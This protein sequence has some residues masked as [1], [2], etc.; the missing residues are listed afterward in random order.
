MQKKATIV[1]GVD[2]GYGRC[3]WA[4]IAK[5][6]R[7]RYGCIETAKEKS[8]PERLAIIA[9]ELRAVIEMHAPTHVAIE[10]L[11]FAKNAKTALPVAESRGVASL[12]ATECLLPVINVKPGQVKLA[13]TGYGHAPKRQVQ[14]M[15][16]ML[17]NI[18]E[19]IQPDD[20]AD[21]L[22]IAMTALRLLSFPRS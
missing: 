18:T 2:P 5:S 8:L 17:L 9:K 19:P 20:A 22:A 1:L 3:G 4:I 13:I 7:P 15:V 16:Q 12:V 21:A 10:E 6:G 11:F 14:T